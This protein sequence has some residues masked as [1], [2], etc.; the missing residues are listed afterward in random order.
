MYQLDTSL[1]LAGL[2]MTPDE[3]GT[4]VDDHHGMVES[5]VEYVTAQ[6]NLSELMDRLTYE[7]TDAILDEGY[8]EGAYTEENYWA[9]KRMVRQHYG[10]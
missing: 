8:K 6:E 7:E 1:E 5:G 2:G 3:I 4:L 10:K 9:L